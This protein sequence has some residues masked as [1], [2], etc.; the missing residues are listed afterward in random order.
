MKIKLLLFV[1]MML[2]MSASAIEIDG[3]WYNL[4]SNGKIAEVTKR[5]SGG[6]S[7]TII[8]I[9]GTETL[10]LITSNGSYSG[11]IE[12]PSKVTYEG[13]EYTVTKIGDDAFNCS[14]KL[15]SVTIPNGVT[16]IGNRAFRYCYRL[17][18]IT[19]PNSITTIGND[20]FANC[21]G[22]TSVT[23]PE[24]VT[25]IGSF[26]FDECTSLSSVSIPDGVVSIEI[27]TF[28]NCTGLTSVTIPKN[29]SSVGTRAFSG[30]GITSIHLPSTV[31]SIGSDAFSDCTK[32]SRVESKME[33]PPVIEDNVFSSYTLKEGTLVVPKG[34]TF[35]YETT[36]GWKNF[37]YIVEEGKEENTTFAVSIEKEG[38]L[39]STV[40]ALE[41]SRVENLTIKGRLN[42]NDIAYLISQK[43]KVAHLYTLDLK[44]VTLVA[45]S[46]PYTSI[47]YGTN[48]DGASTE[49]TYYYLSDENY[50]NK[51]TTGNGLGGVKSTVRYY[52]NHLA[53]AFH[54]MNLRKVVM[55]SQIKQIGERTFENNTS[56]EEV[57]FSENVTVIGGG[58]PGR[59]N[60]AGAFQ[61]C[62]N[63][64]TIPSLCHVEVIEEGAFKNCASISGDIDLSNV[65]F[66]SETAFYG[67]MGIT[68]VT[69]SN[70]LESVGTDAFAACSKLAN[71]IYDK[72]TDA[73]FSR[74]SFLETPWYRNLGNED[75][76][77]YIGKCA[78]QV[79]EGTEPRE[80]TLKSGT[81]SI[82]HDFY[83]SNTC[84]KIRTLNLPQ[85][86]KRIGDYAFYVAFDDGNN[87]ETVNFPENLEEIGASAFEHSQR[88]KNLVIPNSVKKVGDRA[89][90]TCD[91]LEVA[92]INASNFGEYVFYGCDKLKEVTIGENV[93][94]IGNDMFKL[95]KELAK[96]TFL[97]RQN[98]NALEIGNSAF[99]NCNK[100]ISLE[101]PEGTKSIGEN[102]IVCENLEHITLPNSLKYIAGSGISRC[103]KIT[104]LTIPANVTIAKTGA[105][106]YSGYGIERL[107]GL[108]SLTVKSKETYDWHHSSESLEEVLLEEGVE[109]I[110]KSAF[111]SCEKLKAI[112]IPSTVHTIEDYAFLLSGLESLA[113]PSNIN[114]IG[115][116]SLACESLQTLYVYRND[117]LPLSAPFYKNSF[118]EDELDLNSCILYVPKGSKTKYQNADIWKEFKNIE[119]F[120]SET[121]DIGPVTETEEK[122]FNQQM[123]ETTDLSNTVIDN[124]YYNMNAANG[125]GYDATEQALV[126]NSTT[127]S[128]QMNAVQGAQVG[129]AAVKDNFCGVIFE[130]PAGQGTVT[131]DA[132]TI[133][134]HVLNV[135]VGNGAPTKVTK[136]ERGTVDVTY[137]VAAATYVYLYAST[138]DG[139]A[140][141]LHRAAT[142]GANSV[143]L[144]GY[145]VTIGSGTGINAIT[146]DKPV[147]VYTLQ[148][149]KVLSGVTTLSGLT[150]GVY[151]INGRKVVVK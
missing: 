11:T 91:L 76:I 128:T 112:V 125:D 130:V 50:K 25:S 60:Y 136:S 9:R 24:S 32:L 10:N 29:L 99:Y 14:S 40:E 121:V 34:A 43:G 135:Q 28:R 97:T 147:D 118:Y 72:D 57:W 96:V 63:L 33:I 31:T 41:T 75:G 115:F 137:D 129:D 79:S 26:C 58:H 53:G 89:F 138:A 17:P 6:Y 140:A 105:Q 124:T 110:T 70:K 117:P 141:P 30:C 120:S 114:S 16:S 148:G 143:L 38:T 68:G 51:E 19:M 127:S 21:M 27:G 119:E 139:S 102:A 20:A 69:L 3:I 5:P 12:I 8:I 108:K 67:C 13:E 109:V 142:A 113:I 133:G 149:Q 62:T 56:L 101:L 73:V 94:T 46:E 48:S 64:T 55:P 44:D 131:V 87:I 116:G 106:G 93:E 39:S 66:V 123:N 100:L 122:S 54:D 18:S 82:A 146:I 47:F 35:E 144:Y 15:T 111:L 90:A 1:I 52:N 2:P 104:A 61:N 103:G 88:L 59:N 22:L 81:L 107:T 7:D 83:D 49:T 95:S 71:V 150:K 84:G 86:L 65:R 126:L 36:K 92:E 132:K 134:S 74:T 4:I 23:I 80:L 145:K 98:E 37:A 42:G 45:S 85:S 151:I 77:V 78:M